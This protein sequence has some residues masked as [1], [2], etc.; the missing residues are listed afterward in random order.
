MF[1][2][3]C[4]FLII[5]ELL[6]SS[7]RTPTIFQ[8]ETHL[9]VVSVVGDMDFRRKP[10]K[11]Y[12]DTG[13][14]NNREHSSSP[15]IQN[16]RKLRYE[17]ESKGKKVILVTS[18]KSQEGKSIIMESLA[19]TFSMSKKK[20]L[21]IDANFSNNTLTREF[22]AVPTL[23]NFHMN[24]QDSSMDKIWGITTLT[25]ITNTDIVGCGE[26][27]YTPSEILPPNNLFSNLNKIVQHYDFILI[28]GAALND[29][30]D[31]RE[32]AEYA[33]GIV[34]VFSAKNSIH[35]S[36]KEAIQFLNTA[37]NKFIGVVLNMVDEDNFDL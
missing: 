28:E 4:L 6:D 33:E 11:E 3:A 12:L 7:L 31:S 17:I 2:I 24:G 10:L 22:S 23:E 13:I 34:A 1:F 20:V 25:S 29:H 36:D 8:K 16:L 5:L 15:F 19:Y 9:N 32:L 18:P 27:N 30:A 21:L 26:G 14:Q 37:G 35:E